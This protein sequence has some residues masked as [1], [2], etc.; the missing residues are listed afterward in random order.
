MLID[1][2]KKEYWTKELLV[3]VLGNHTVLSEKE[4]ASFDLLWQAKL[5]CEKTMG[6]VIQPK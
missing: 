3:L 6:S 4:K 1:W 2:S 5:D